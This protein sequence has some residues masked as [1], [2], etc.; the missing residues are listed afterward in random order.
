VAVHRKKSQ[1]KRIALE[2]IEALFEMAENEAMK[3]NWTRANRYVDL[4]RTIGM[5]YNVTPGPAL[6]RKFCRGC[7]TFLLPP[8]TARIRVG[9]GKVVCTCLKCGRVTRYPYV[10]ERRDRRRG[11]ETGNAK[12]RETSE[13]AGVE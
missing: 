9:D 5:R 10:R 2:R 3:K 6:R 12:M 7:G 11:R 13:E 8:A 1:E 4:A